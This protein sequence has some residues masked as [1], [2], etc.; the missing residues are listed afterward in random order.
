MKQILKITRKISDLQYVGVDSSGKSYRVESTV[1]VRVG[2]TVRVSNGRIT[3][4][5]R[6]ETITVYNI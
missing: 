4:V 3:G 6:A 2:Q 1:V 5:I